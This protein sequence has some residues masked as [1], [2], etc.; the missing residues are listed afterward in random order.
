[1]NR[2]LQQWPPNLRVEVFGVSAR[3]W[4][5]GLTRASTEPVTL[6]V[7]LWAEEVFAASNVSLA[8]FGIDSHADRCVELRIRVFPTIRLLIGGREIARTEHLF[9]S[10]EELA[11][12]VADRVELHFGGTDY[13]THTAHW[14]DY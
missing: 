1:M 5:S 4:T 3:I 6:L 10:R 7:W 14:G 11:V 9:F 13:S 8:Y 2:A 12:W